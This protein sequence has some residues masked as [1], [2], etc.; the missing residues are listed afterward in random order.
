[1][2]LHNLGGY[3]LKRVNVLRPTVGLQTLLTV[4]G[5][6]TSSVIFSS[7]RVRNAKPE[8]KVMRNGQMMTHLSHLQVDDTEY[9]RYVAVCCCPSC[10]CAASRPVDAAPAPP[11]RIPCPPP[12]ATNTQHIHKTGLGIITQHS[13]YNKFL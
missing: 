11:T 5:A 10:C 6:Y 7:D 12:L 1:M 4:G 2:G 9:L 8:K 13:K 3:L